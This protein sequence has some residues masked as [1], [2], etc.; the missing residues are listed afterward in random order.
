MLVLV[1]VHSLFMS[2]KLSLFH[3][4]HTQKYK[5]C[6]TSWTQCVVCVKNEKWITDYSILTFSFV[7]HA[8]WCMIPVC[9]LL[10]LLFTL[11]HELG[12]N[13]WL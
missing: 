3:Q 2:V 4:G 5:R 9:A 6:E 8:I 12:F 1:S 10:T 7:G 11:F 13:N